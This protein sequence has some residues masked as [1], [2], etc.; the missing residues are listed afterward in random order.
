MEWLQVVEETGVS[1]VENDDGP[2][3]SAGKRGW[4]SRLVPALGL[5][6]AMA[7]FFGLGLDR[8]VSLEL[9]RDNRE[10]LTG[11]VADHYLL[12][13]LAFVVLY[14][15]VTGLSVPG[16]AVLTLSGGFLFG[17]FGGTAYAVTGA[18]IGATAVFWAAR[19]AFGDALRARAGKAIGM[20]REGFRRDAFNYLLFLRLVPAFPFFV[21]NLVPAFLGVSTRTYV[22][23]TVI[24]IIPGGF[25]F[26]TVG[27]GLGSIFDQQ[28]KIGLGDIMTPEIIMA[29]VGLGL[30]ALIP[31]AAKRF[32]GRR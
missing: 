24:G 29:M 12:A 14:A 22:L 5:V 13:A 10:V 26:A 9:L 15:V 3:A 18:T 4:T 2:Q 31:V 17:A 21:V 11:F 23:A 32:L 6:L 19:T 28:G 30:L 25:V 8:Y 27:A 1:G 20:M 7:L 16:A